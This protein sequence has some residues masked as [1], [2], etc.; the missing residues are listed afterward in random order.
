MFSAISTHH[1][2]AQRDAVAARSAIGQSPSI[3]IYCPVREPSF[4]KSL[5]TG[6]NPNTPSRYRV[7]S[8]VREGSF[9][10][11]D[12]AQHYL[13]AFNRS[14]MTKDRFA[15][16]DD[17]NEFVDG[18]LAKLDSSRE[19]PTCHTVLTRR[20]SAVQELQKLNDTLEE[21]SETECPTGILVLSR[22]DSTDTWQFPTRATFVRN[23]VRGSTTDDNETKL[24]SFA[25]NLR[26]PM[27]Q[28]TW[29]ATQ[30]RFKHCK[31]Y[32]MNSED[33]KELVDKG[34]LGETGY[35]DSHTAPYSSYP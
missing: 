18:Q 6:R 28:A 22:R 14:V 34:I 8:A 17:F 21:L 11:K 19:F 31:P 33:I 29:E 25:E 23:A 12:L 26:F 15:S 7:I 5:F 13:T 4:M 9:L 16:G 30:R 35:E 2:P 10:T 32:F 3:V 1:Q 20:P 27:D 24:N